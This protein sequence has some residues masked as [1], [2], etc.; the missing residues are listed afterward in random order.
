MSASSS[1][2]VRDYG[3]NRRR[4]REDRG[5]ASVASAAKTDRLPPAPR[6]RRPMLAALGVLLIVGGAATSGLLALRSDE[7]VPVLVASRDIAAGEE[8][9]AD[10][11]TTTSVASEDTHLIPA[12]QEDQLVGQYARLTISSGQLMDTAMLMRTAALRPG[13]VA[14]GA[15]LGSGRVPALGLQAGDVVDLIA[16]ADG[17]GEVLAEGVLVSSFITANET[18]AGSGAATATFIVDQADGPRIAAVNAA[19]ELAVVLVERGTA[20]EG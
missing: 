12:S 16:V 19:G 9:T 4:A 5:V 6:E 8:I 17:V 7:R 11:L 1:T 3:H 18:G 14:V 10:A 15:E 20:W 13:S 2:P